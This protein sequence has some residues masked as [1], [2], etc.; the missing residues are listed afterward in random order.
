MSDRSRKLIEET[1]AELRPVFKRM[2]E[3]EYVC[4]KRVLDA[5]RNNRV[6]ARHFNFT[7][8]Y[9]YD[10]EGRDT[11]DRIFA[12]VMQTEAALAVPQ[13]SSGTH[14]IFTALAAI[15]R[16]SDVI[17]SAVG[18]PY[19]T[20]VEAIGI[21]GSAPGSLKEFGIGY[22]EIALG[23]DGRI[24]LAALERELAAK[25]KIVYFQRSRGYEWRNAILPSEMKPAFDLVKKLSPESVIMV[26]NCYGEFTQADEPTAYGADIIVGSLIKNPGGGIAHTG[27]YIA[28]RKDLIELAANR[29]TV[30]GIGREAGSYAGG[31]L[32]YYQGLFLAPHTVCQALK[33]AAL[34][35][36]VFEKLG[37]MSMPSST[38]ERSDVVQALRFPEKE[39]LINFCRV[40]QSVS[41]VDSFVAPEPWA[42]PGYTSEVIM[43][44]GTFVQGASIELTADAPI[45][46]PYTAYIQGGLTYSHGRIAAET[47]LDSLIQ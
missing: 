38:A 2:E 39:Q 1:E 25:P 19:D 34:F 5:F 9:G 32:P 14:T 37:L 35:A 28:G 18:R 31:Y 29:V 10:D 3:V 40:I 20:L 47:V 4:Q 16:P 42:M 23:G 44:A 21:E 17:L 11:L 12:E 41:P 13:L 36:G 7:T 15:L 26:D 27:G 22:R 24:D 43:A 6:A 46:E 8:G 30:P 45:R 33:T